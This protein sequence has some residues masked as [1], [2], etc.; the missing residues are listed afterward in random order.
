MMMAIAAAMTSKIRSR[1]A[2]SVHSR[3]LF[4]APLLSLWH[5]LSF[6]LKRS[7]SFTRR[8]SGRTIQHSLTHRHFQ[9]PHYHHRTRQRSLA[10]WRSRKIRTQSTHWHPQIDWLC[11]QCRLKQA[12][13]LQCIFENRST[14]T[15]FHWHW[16]LLDPTG[17]NKINKCSIINQY[18]PGGSTLKRMQK[19]DSGQLWSELISLQPGNVV[20]SCK[21]QSMQEELLYNMPWL[22]P[23]GAQIVVPGYQ[24]PK[25]FLS[26]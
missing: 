1:A 15:R 13:I 9:L 19:Y 7:F 6:V 18:W 10:E 12:Q 22:E 14:I 20:Q 17:D 21:Q 16:S 4:F 25:F 2:A 24:K 5:D 11:H 26:C 23:T 8:R 3:F